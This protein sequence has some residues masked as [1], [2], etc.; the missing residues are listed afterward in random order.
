[1]N[2]TLGFKLGNYQFRARY[3]LTLSMLIVLSLFLSLGFWQLARAKEKTNLQERFQNRRQAAPVDITQLPANGDI[4]Y[5]AVTMTGHYDNDHA[6]LLD[7][8][9]YQHRIGYEVLTPFLLHNGKAVLINRGWIPAS[10][11]RAELPAIPAENGQKTVQG[12]IY[13]PPGKP[14]TLGKL[15]ENHEQWPLRVQAVQIPM[16][17]KT[18]KQSLYG[19]LV[20]LSPQENQGFIR[21]WQPINMPAHKH[22][23]YAA[24]WF[25]FAA[26]LIIIFTVLNLRKSP[27][28]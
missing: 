20:L 27:K 26:V 13:L 10:K 8:K 3:S 22:L 21:D 2:K 4:R 15:I 28:P 18:L 6:I 24:Q 23:G 25:T 7:N 12:M 1:M 19:F 14:F 16:L 17:E 5:Q 11:T 9:I